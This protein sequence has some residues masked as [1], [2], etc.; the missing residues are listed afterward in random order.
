MKGETGRGRVGAFH[1]ADEHA[2]RGTAWT[3]GRQVRAS[4]PGVTRLDPEFATRWRGVMIPSCGERRIHVEGS[5][6]PEDGEEASHR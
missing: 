6:R 4:K 1:P 5:I 3:Y 2:C